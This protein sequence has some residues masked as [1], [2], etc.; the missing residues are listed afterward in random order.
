MNIKLIISFALAV[1]LIV[2]GASMMGYFHDLHFSLKKT[3]SS[4]IKWINGPP[5]D[6]YAKCPTNKVVAIN[7][8]TPT[9]D[10][11]N[12]I[13]TDAW[14]PIE[15]E[16]STDEILIEFTSEIDK[17]IQPNELFRFYRDKNLLFDPDVREEWKETIVNVQAQYNIIKSAS[18]QTYNKVSIKNPPKGLILIEFNTSKTVSGGKRIC[19]H[20]KYISFEVKKI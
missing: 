4:L 2:V 3:V 6:T 11:K 19:G 20:Q 10:D 8:L 14:Q 9:L 13:F 18:S 12:D 16:F 5:I 7:I 17:N 1:I 15:K